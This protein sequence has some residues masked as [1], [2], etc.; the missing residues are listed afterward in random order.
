MVEQYVHRRSVR[1]GT[2]GRV[3]EEHIDGRRLRYQHRRPELLNDIA[4]YVLEHGVGGLAMRP[5]AVALGVSHGTLL[6]HFIY[7]LLFEVY[8]QAAAA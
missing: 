5:L 4:D 8:A 6:H 3:D 1:L 7:R 2:V